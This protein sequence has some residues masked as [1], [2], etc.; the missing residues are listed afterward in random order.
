MAKLAV[1]LCTL[2][3]NPLRAQAAGMA[4]DSP[5]GFPKTGALPARWAPDL[6]EEF[7]PVEKDYYLFSSPCRSL[8]QIGRIQSEMPSGTFTLPPQDWKFLPRTR[9][10]LREGG[11]LRL[12]ALG[13]SI[14]NDMMRSG[15]VGRLAEAYPG[16]GV[17]ALV[18]VRG[19]GGCQHYR[20]ESRV[21]KF[22]APQG[23]NLVLIGGIS[24][25]D[26][27]SIRAVIGQIREHLP[28]VEF[29]LVTGAF[30]TTDPRDP[31]ALAVAPHS[32][33]GPYGSALRQLA[34]EERCAY[35]DLTTPW[36]EYIRSSR[37]HPHLF[38]RDAV[39]ANEFGEQILGRI[40]ISFFRGA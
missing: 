24:Q 8:E 27:E 19:G 18:Y 32:G 11:Q 26:T 20:E 37:L 29:L 5:I 23:P 6:K 3:L 36:A 30:G 35:L 2:A 4:A 31:S 22:L 33:T 15:W 25:K 38:Y 21:A 13:D 10:T 12:L 1:L 34:G 14:V 40:L 28:E 17:K 9:R 39:H 7:L 16:A